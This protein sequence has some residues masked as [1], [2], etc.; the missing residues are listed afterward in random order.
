MSLLALCP[1]KRHSEHAEPGHLS[2]QSVSYLGQFFLFVESFMNQLTQNL[3]F[4]EALL[5]FN[6][7]HFL[8][9]G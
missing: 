2:S 5:L 6:P 1:P 7:T 9:F 3:Q 4:L 8:L